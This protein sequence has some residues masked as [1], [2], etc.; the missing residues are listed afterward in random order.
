[1]HKTKFM[2]QLEN[3]KNLSNKYIFKTNKL[4]TNILLSYC[5]SQWNYKLLNL[6]FEDKVFVDFKEMLCNY[7]LLN[8][9]HNM[10][11]ITPFSPPVW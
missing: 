9:T 8:A 10:L 3:M 2:Y 6:K 7:I 1:M 11:L 5:Q 4:I